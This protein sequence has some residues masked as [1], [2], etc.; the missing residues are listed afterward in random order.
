MYSLPGCRS[1]GDSGWHVTWSADDSRLYYIRPLAGAHL[2]KSV[3]L[4]DSST[5]EHGT[6]GPLM[7]IGTFF[8]VSAEGEVAWVRYE[9]GTGEIWLTRLP[10]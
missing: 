9:R 4:A 6:I 8:D 1:L 2:I 3:S 7:D 5:T 10:D